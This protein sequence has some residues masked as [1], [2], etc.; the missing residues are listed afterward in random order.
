[1]GYTLNGQLSGD[2]SHITVDVQNYQ[3]GASPEEWDAALRA[4]LESDI[5]PVVCDRSVP[6]A[7]KSKLKS[8]GKTPSLAGPSGAH[9]LSNW[10]NRTTS[11]H[12][13]SQWRN[14]KRLGI[15]LQT[16][17]VRA[18]DIDI[19]DPTIAAQVEATFLKA[20]GNVDLPVRGRPNSGKRLLA[21]VVEGFLSKRRFLTGSGAVE[22][23]ANGQQ[24]VF[25][26]QHT[27][28]V[29]Y[30]W[31]EGLPGVFPVVTLE[32]LDSAWYAIS[33]QFGTT[34]DETRLY[35]PRRRGADHAI[36]DPVCDHLYAQN[37]VLDEGRDGALYVECPWKGEHTSDSGVTETAWYP[38]GSNGYERGHFKCLHAHCAGR[39][40]SEF[41]RAVGFDETGFE[42]VVDHRPQP[43]PAALAKAWAFRD[44]RSIPPREWLYGGH[45]IRKF[46][47]ATI[48]PG[49]AGKSALTLLE[50]MA[51]A[52]G[53]DLLDVKPAARARVW[54]FN[55]EDPLEEIERRIAAA[56][57]YYGIEAHE[58]EG[59]LFIGS[60]RETEIAIASQT[61]QGVLPN[62]ET[63]NDILE[64][65]KAHDIALLIVDPFVSSH[66]VAE[67]DNGAVD[68]VVKIW[69]RIA[70]QTGCAVELVHH[71]RKSA[72]GAEVTVEDSRGAS[73]LI[74]AARSARALNRMTRAEAEKAL[75]SNPRS[76]F[77]VTSGK[78]NLAP[79]P[80]ASD[81]YRFQSVNLMN[82]AEL[83]E[84]DSVGVVTRWT[85]PEA[86]PVDFESIV[87]QLQA[88]VLAS[89][90]KA[91]E[92]PKAQNWLGHKLAEL[93]GLEVSAHR[94][95][96]KDILL[97]MV[98]R[99]YLGTT[100]RQ[101][102]NRMRRT[103]YVALQQ[104]KGS[105][106][107]D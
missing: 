50:A 80:E 103:Y 26:G 24:F 79:P 70:D 7:P 9:G 61:R 5:L 35:T 99:G 77:R 15:S 91:R 81:W 86:A 40:D 56:R 87:P 98:C 57:L 28:G 94:Q 101:D 17:R 25:A 1:M 31:R 33:A 73:A 46:V 83:G 18:L 78:E 96:L 85:W 92:S 51:I 14:D 42:P 71:A 16:R 4:G 2:R 95:Q 69:G 43:N 32:Q 72:P 59:W 39:T 36:G 54:Y 20:L 64:T 74:A 48:A 93:A 66:R 22:F 55:G 23:L 88:F 67:N 102:E 41:K 19:D 38:A 3:A 104:S 75:V 21:F 11:A 29:R 58:L 53:R 105:M 27:S 107:N 84:G 6:I 62:L 106:Q 82:G 13:I 37:L 89:P 65:I 68:A 76:C 10:T 60:G 47:S 63:L 52:T 45:Y 97:Q 30:T 49:G 90:D 12:E 34:I 44:P 100:D 8:L